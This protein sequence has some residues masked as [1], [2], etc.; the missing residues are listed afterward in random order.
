MHCAAHAGRLPRSQPQRPASPSGHAAPCRPAFVPWLQRHGAR[1]PRVRGGEP[2]QRRPPPRLR[3]LGA[4]TV[5]PAARVC[6]QGTAHALPATRLCGL[7]TRL[8]RSGLATRAAL[9]QVCCLQGAQAASRPQSL[10]AAGGSPSDRGAWQP[11]PGSVAAAPQRLLPHMAATQQPG[12]C[13]R[14]QH[15][16]AGGDG[17]LQPSHRHDADAQH[18]IAS[19][20]GAVAAQMSV[21]H[22]LQP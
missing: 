6:D 22:Q 4:T 17:G 14:L 5:P 13:D 12:R 8:L 21:H 18:Q 9:P 1:L 19:R 2:Q 7:H 3:L 10:A 20:G 11:A 15:Q 16:A